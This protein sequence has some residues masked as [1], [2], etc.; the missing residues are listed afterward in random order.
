MNGKEQAYNLSEKE[1]K[2]VQEIQQEL[3][4]EVDRICKKCRIHYN[5]VG[6]NVR[7]NSP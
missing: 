2:Q 1:L 6:N 3:I 7:S 4:R 5:M